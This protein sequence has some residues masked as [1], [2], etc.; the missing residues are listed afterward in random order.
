[1][2]RTIAAFLFIFTAT[3]AMGQAKAPPP[4]NAK[5][6]AQ[7]LFTNWAGADAT[8]LFGNS[9]YLYKGRSTGSE[10]SE[11]SVEFDSRMP[12]RF[13]A[14]VQVGDESGLAE[15]YG[16]NGPVT[17]RYVEQRSVDGSRTISSPSLV[18]SS[19]AL[20][21]QVVFNPLSLFDIDK[22]MS[23]LNTVGKF[24]FAGSIC[25]RVIAMPRAETIPMNFFF[26]VETG[27]FKGLDFK[28]SD[29]VMEMVVSEYRM[30][31]IGEGQEVNFPSGFT[32]L[33][34]GE[35]RNRV[36]VSSLTRVM[37]LTKDEFEL[38]EVIKELVSP[39]Q[40]VSVDSKAGNERL[41]SMIGPN[42][43]DASGAM[44]SSSV[45]KTKKNVLLYFSAKWCPPCRKFTPTLV[46]FFDQNAQAK[47]FTIVFVSSDRS[48]A[49]QMKY[50]T[51]YKMD[52]FAVPL[53]RVNASGLKQ[54][55][56]DRGIPNLVWLNP[57]G[58]AVAKSYV[59]GNYVGP[60][61]VLAEFSRAMDIN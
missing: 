29:T 45:L 14:K 59:D 35:V 27:L 1:M 11:L 3:T 28:S 22:K 44:V 47:D 51:D 32:L 30:F 19:V 16:S 8:R 55:Y 24:N 43:V 10:D 52:F 33:S 13:R 49:D 34:K 42:L 21:N 26:D 36:D 25:W 31:S 20:A 41:I 9:A 40:P 2:I 58:T 53:D 7:F 39:S 6:S 18:T 57:E 38:P 4:V 5:P 15:V 48:A 17:W 37:K 61:R 56:G 54:T 60:N 23:R 46:N 12:W 50:M